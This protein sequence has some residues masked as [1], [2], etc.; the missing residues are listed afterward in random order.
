MNRELAH[1]EIDK[2]FNST[3]PGEHISVFIVQVDDFD[4]EQHMNSCKFEKAKAN[5]K[6]AVDDVCD[7]VEE[8]FFEQY[9]RDLLTKASDEVELQED[10]NG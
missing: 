10:D 4:L 1:E 7:L 3:G 6:Q 8:M 5:M 9:F 2:I